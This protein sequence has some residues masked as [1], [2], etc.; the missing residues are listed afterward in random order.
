[1]TKYHPVTHLLGAMT[2]GGFYR[3]LCEHH[4][5]SLKT[6]TDPEK[7]TCAICTWRM[8]KATLDIQGDTC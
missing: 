2:G 5:A 6:T 1:M 3:T 8:S 4:T 7:V